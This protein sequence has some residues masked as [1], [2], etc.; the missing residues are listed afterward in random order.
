MHSLSVAAEYHTSTAHFLND[1][2]GK[3][4]NLH[5][6]N[7]EFAVRVTLATAKED[8]PALNAAAMLVDFGDLKAF[9]R[10]FLE[11]WDHALLVP[12]TEEEVDNFI[13][14]SGGLENLGVW[15]LRDRARI[16]GFGVNPTAEAMSQRIAAALVKNLEEGKLRLPKHAASVLTDISVQVQVKETPGCSALASASCDIR[17]LMWL[18]YEP[19]IGGDA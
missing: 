17:K 5:G 11:P 14:A 3:C 12:M 4:A 18:S 7:Y 2:Q 1:Y 16:I 9:M 15:G 6:H 13:E 19:V 8:A 10:A